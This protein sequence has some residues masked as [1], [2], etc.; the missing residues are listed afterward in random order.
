[1]GGRKVYLSVGQSD[2][3]REATWRWPHPPPPLFLKPSPF[4]HPETLLPTLS[5]LVSSASLVCSGLRGLLLQGAFPAPYPTLAPRVYLLT[6]HL[7]LVLH[8]GLPTDCLGFILY[9][10][11]CSPPIFQMQTLRPKE[12]MSVGGSSPAAWLL[13]TLLPQHH[14]AGPSSNRSEDLWE[15]D[16]SAA[17]QPLRCTFLLVYYTCPFPP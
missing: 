10:R 2:L 14:L 11:C 16:F 15:S 6:A 5:R 3:G 17:P 9:S 4:Q 7:G 1:M 12:A 8:T 13:R